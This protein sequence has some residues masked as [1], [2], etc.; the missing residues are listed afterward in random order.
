MPG[1]FPI[2]WTRDAWEACYPLGERGWK[3]WPWEPEPKPPMTGGEIWKA[4]QEFYRKASEAPMRPMQRIMSPWEFANDV[5]PY[6][7]R[8]SR[9]PI[10]DGPPLALPA[11]GA[12]VEPATVSPATR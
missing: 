7:V 11:E 8:T 4:I 5:V 1:P 12:G 6:S 3:P 10:L 2:R 9:I